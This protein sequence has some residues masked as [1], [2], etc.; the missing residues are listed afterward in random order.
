[1]QTSRKL[2][3]YLSG[4]LIV[5]L[6]FVRSSSYGSGS[7]LGLGLGSGSSPGSGC[8][9]WGW[10]VRHT[11]VVGQ[12]GWSA[13]LAEDVGHVRSRTTHMLLPIHDIWLPK[14]V[15]WCYVIVCTFI[16]P[17][18][19]SNKLPYLFQATRCRTPACSAVSP[20]GQT[21]GRDSSEGSHDTVLVRLLPPQR[22]SGAL[23]A[24][25]PHVPLHRRRRWLFRT[26]PCWWGFLVRASCWGLWT[27]PTSGVLS[28]S[29][30]STTFLGTIAPPPRTRSLWDFFV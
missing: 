9:C 21:A 3:N 13:V 6:I 17:L 20:G 22:A 8:S 26:H 25:D 16:Y 10:R 4:F 11:R 12:G 19:I 28:S 29:L 2:R 30:G 24:G 15:N 14:Y 1:M 18:I 5:Y 7:V 27:S 23:E